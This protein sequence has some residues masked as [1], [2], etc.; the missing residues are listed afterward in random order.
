VKT[1]AGFGDFSQQQG[2]V[3]RHPTTPILRLKRELRKYCKVVGID[4]YNTNKTCSSCSNPIELYRNRMKGVLEPIARMS[5]INSVIRCKTNECKLCCLDRD[6]N[7][8]QNILGLLLNQYRGE[9]RPI[10]FKYKKIG[11]IPRKS[12]KRP[13]ACDSSL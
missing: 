2:L 13:K 4:E 8:S 3:K 5:N 10:C 12:D 6:I 11:V 1:L 9:E 7:A